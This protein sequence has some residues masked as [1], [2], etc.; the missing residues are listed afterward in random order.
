MLK[1]AKGIVHCAFNSRNGYQHTL[2]V[3]KSK[4]HILGHLTSSTH[5]RAMKNLSKIGN[6]KVYG[7]EADSIPTWEDSFNEWHK[8]GRIH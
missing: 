4:E 1:K 3:W 8:N 2:T 7:Y 5:L 6:G